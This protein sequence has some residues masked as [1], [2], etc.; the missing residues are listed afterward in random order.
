[1]GRNAC[2]NFAVRTL[3]YQGLEKE[4][5]RYLTSDTQLDLDNDGVPDEVISPSA[6]NLQ[7]AVEWAKD[8]DMLVLY[9]VNHGGKDDNGKGFFRLSSSETLSAAQLDAWLDAFQQNS[10]CKVTV[11]YDACKSGTFLT[12][13]TAPEGKERIVITGTSPD[14]DALF[15]SQGTNSFSLYFWTN[16]FNGTDVQSAF[17][18]TRKTGYAASQHRQSHDDRKQREGLFGNGSILCRRFWLI[19]ARLRTMR[20]MRALKQRRSDDDGIARV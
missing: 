12:E 20:S 7:T 15:I 1:M 19:Y 8:A 17:L 11:I 10:L 3:A 4:D 9:M 18:H 6:A 2:A 14:E 16:I 5:I 13:L